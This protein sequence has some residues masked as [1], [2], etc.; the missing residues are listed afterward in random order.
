MGLI[1]GVRLPPDGARPSRGRCSTAISRKGAN[2]VM[3]A[4]DALLTREELL[5][6][7]RVS[8]DFLYTPAGRTLPTIKIGNRVMIR[9]AALGA[10]LRQR[11]GLAVPT[12]AGGWH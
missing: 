5:R 10:W 6:E 4:S 3:D 1:R 7:L 2:S 8:K 12:A 11:E 9:R